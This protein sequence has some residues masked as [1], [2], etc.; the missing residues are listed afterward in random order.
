VAVSKLEG[1]FYWEELLFCFF[2]HP[3]KLS[4]GTQKG[5]LISDS[6]M[7]FFISFMAIVIYQVRL[8]GWEPKTAL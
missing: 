8:S 5:K 2:K 6:E 4:H 7:F 3:I 1:H